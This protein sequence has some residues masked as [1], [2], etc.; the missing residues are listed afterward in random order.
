VGVSERKGR[1]KGKG[2][3]GLVREWR[4]EGMNGGAERLTPRHWLSHILLQFPPPQLPHPPAHNI[5]SR[6]TGVYR[7]IPSHKH[8]QVL[9]RT[10][11]WRK[12]LKAITLRNWKIV[13]MVPPYCFYSGDG[14]FVTASHI[15]IYFDV[16]ADEC[17]Y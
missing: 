4:N 9:M 17:R 3:N 15:K 14:I 16:T 11:S 6:T 7:Y 8:F 10:F 13:G 5:L 12:T 2:E 1:E